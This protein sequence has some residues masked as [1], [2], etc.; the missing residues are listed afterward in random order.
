[1]CFQILKLQIKFLGPEYEI[2]PLCSSLLLEGPPVLLMKVEVEM[3]LVV[4]YLQL[5]KSVGETGIVFINEVTVIISLPFK[6]RILHSSCSLTG[7]QQC[8]AEKNE[9]RG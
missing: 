6:H 9:K 5:K 2:C 1:M 8:V 7:Q 4:M 3:M